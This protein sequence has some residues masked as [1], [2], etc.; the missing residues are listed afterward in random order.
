MLRIVGFEL[1]VMARTWVNVTVL[2]LCH[3]IYE[4]DLLNTTEASSWEGDVSTW[5]DDGDPK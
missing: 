5:R 1:L 2:K 3:A 4:S